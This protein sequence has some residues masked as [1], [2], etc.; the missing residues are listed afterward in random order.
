MRNQVTNQMGRLEFN[1]I[2]LNTINASFQHLQ[3]LI[4]LVHEK[5]QKLK[6]IHASQKPFD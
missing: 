1:H 3:N 4:L 6:I 2:P 5:N